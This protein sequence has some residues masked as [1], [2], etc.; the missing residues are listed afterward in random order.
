VPIDSLSDAFGCTDG[1]AVFSSSYGAQQRCTPAGCR[2]I[3]GAA[4]TYEPFK[5]KQSFWADLNGKVL[6]VASTERR[7]GLRYRYS[8]GKNL[9]DV[10]ADKILFDDLIKDGKVQTDST[11]LGLLLG[12]RGRYAV[13]LMT[14]PKGVYALRF[15]A[16][17]KPTPAT[18][19]R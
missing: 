9:G 3:D 10:G 14:T 8:D 15:D 16:D 2:D 17:G 13:A 7:G 18:I 5:V 1:E 6:N 11:L 19:M 12:G 4:S